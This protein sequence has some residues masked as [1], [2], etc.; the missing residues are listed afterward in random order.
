[1]LPP[2]LNLPRRLAEHKDKLPVNNYCFKLYSGKDYIIMAVSRPNERSDYHM[3]ETKVSF[4]FLRF[5]WTNDVQSAAGVFTGIHFCPF[6]DI[7]TIGHSKG[8][9]SILVPGSGEADSFE[10]CK[11]RREREVRGLLDKASPNI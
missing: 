10:N 4:A 3:N 5:A 1:M 6:Q 9:S 2:L 11:V 8:L 7:L